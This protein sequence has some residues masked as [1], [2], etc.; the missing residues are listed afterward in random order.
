MAQKVSSG[1]L[2]LN[3]DKLNERIM[4][5]ISE[6]ELPEMSKS[7]T[8]IYKKHELLTSVQIDQELEVF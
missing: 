3:T 7:S 4:F 2:Y 6:K 8:N 1:V 5:L